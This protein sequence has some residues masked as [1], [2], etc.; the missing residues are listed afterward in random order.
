MRS[1]TLPTHTAA[2][3]AVV[4]GLWLAAATVLIA[5]V[6][7]AF[8]RGFADDVTTDWIVNGPRVAFAAC[9]GAALG[10]SGSRRLARGSVAPLF[11]MRLLACTAGAA[12][13]GLLAAEI[14]NGSWSLLTFPLGAAVGAIALDRL[15]VALDRPQ[16][17][18]NPVLGLVLAGLAGIIAFAGTYARERTDGIQSLVAWFLGDLGSASFAAAAVLAPF[19]ALL[20]ILACR[21]SESTNRKWIDA[22]A[23]ALAVGSAGPLAFVGTF[24]PRTVHWLT[25]AASPVARILTASICTAATVA[26]ID[27]VPRLLL[28]GYD[29]P[30][31]LPAA[32]LAI[33]VFLGWNRQRLL[34][35][36]GPAHMAFEIIEVVVIAGLTVGAI[37]LGVTLSTFI[38]MAT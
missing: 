25:P 24:A 15:V 19:V 7:A 11:E 4:A 9:V 17:W 3:G 36:A 29:F 18:T 5:C 13:T 34:H 27:S 8:R 2:P 16:R 28:G 23:L 30:W 14:A 22:A 20:L 35:V 31:N 6:L 12:G 38:G 10:L 33:P 32:M 21:A 37:G 26:A 1:A